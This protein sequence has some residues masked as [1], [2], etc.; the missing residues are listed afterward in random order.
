MTDA[1]NSANRAA[2]VDLLAENARL[3]KAEEAEKFRKAAPTNEPA[4]PPAD[5]I[6][7]SAAATR[8]MEGP[9]FDAEKVERIKQAIRDGNYPLDSRRIAESFLAIE[10]MI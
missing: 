4:R 3:K 8:V 6:R 2:R 10:K 9:D 5:E 1:I 7:L